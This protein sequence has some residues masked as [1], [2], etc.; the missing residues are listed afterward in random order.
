MRNVDILYKNWSC[1][2]EVD[3]VCNFN[4]LKVNSQPMGKLYVKKELYRHSKKSLTEQIKKVYFNDPVTV[5]IFEDGSKS[6]V[7]CSENDKYDPEKGFLMALLKKEL[8]NPSKVRKFFK[9]WNTPDPMLTEDFYE[10]S[11]DI[12]VDAFKKRISNNQAIH[13]GVDDE[14]EGGYDE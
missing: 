5:V 8:G 9:K 3:T 6:I 2:F 4:P 10:D 13:Y 1:D 7:R 12:L 14:I 11:K